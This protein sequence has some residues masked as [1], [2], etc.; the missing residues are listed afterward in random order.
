MAIR[1]AE[2]GGKLRKTRRAKELKRGQEV[3]K[4]SKNDE[5]DGVK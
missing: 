1:V 3:A 2:E 5:N 4:A